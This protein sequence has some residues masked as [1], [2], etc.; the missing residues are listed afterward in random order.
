MTMAETLTQSGTS[1]SS[2]IRVDVL[3][4]FDQFLALRDAWDGLFRDACNAAP[5][6][7]HEWLSAWWRVNGGVYGNG[8]D[9]LRVLCIWRNQ[10]E[11][12]GVL[13]L[14]QRRAQRIAEGGRWL[15]YLSTGEPEADE[16]CPDYM[17]LLCK[18]EMRDVCADLAWRTL[19][20]ELGHSYDRLELPSMADCS[21]MVKWARLQGS[22][23]DLQVSPAGVCPLADLGGGFDAYLGRLSGN[24][25]QQARRLLRAAQGAKV[26]LEVAGTASEA[27]EYL[28]QMIDL[29][30]ARWQA[31]GKPGCFASR[32]FTEFH[33]QLAAVWVPQG[34]AILSRLRCGEDVLAVKY[35][36]VSGPKY[37]FYQSGVKMDEEAPIRSPGIVSFL[38][39]M[40]HVCDR[41]ISTFDFLRG[42]SG[43]KYRLATSAQPLVSVRRVVWTWRTGFGAVAE[44]G[45]RAARRLVRRLAG[46]GNRGHK[47]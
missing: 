39:L 2:T 18:R 23:H 36:F 46:A 1:D 17:D 31:V 25:R 34:K 4:C 9:A 41:G 44:L 27:E 43:Y 5:P 38:M 33:R 15:T 19:C 8:R 35:G 29:H 22:Q 24:T 47:G 13:P 3:C 28:Q 37:D 20:G 40:R 14:Y 32:R 16:I 6:L 45:G 7:Q 30:Q 11:L 12:I 26:S 10:D 21:V 42:A